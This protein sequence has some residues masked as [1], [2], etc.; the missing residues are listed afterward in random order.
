MESDPQ[1]AGHGCHTHHYHDPGWVGTLL[2]YLDRDA[3][4]YPGTTIQR[5]DDADTQAQARMAAATLQWYA[6]PGMSEVTTVPYAQNRLFAFLDSTD[7]LS[8]RSR[9]RANAVGHRRIFRIHL[10]VP[11]SAIEKI[12]G[13]SRRR[14]QEQTAAADRRP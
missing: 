3:T 10:T 9:R 12:Y 6:A 1:Y 5:F 11:T 7:Q 8:Q 13:V 4:G 14:Y 2:L